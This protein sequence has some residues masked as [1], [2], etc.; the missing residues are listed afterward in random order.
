MPKAGFSALV[1]D[2]GT[3]DTSYSNAAVSDA[4]KAQTEGCHISRMLY[5]YNV[6][7]ILFM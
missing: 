1:L 6:S 5:N 7:Y 3:S 4:G 2:A